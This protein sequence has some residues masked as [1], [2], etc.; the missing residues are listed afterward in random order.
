MP[1]NVVSE[2]SVALPGLLGGQPL[3]LQQ[4][5]RPLVVQP[6]VQRR[7]F[8]ID[9]GWI[10]AFDRGGER[11]GRQSPPSSKTPQLNTAP[12]AESVEGYGTR[13][14]LVVEDQ[15][16]CGEHEV[17]DQ[18]NEGDAVVRITLVRLRISWPPRR[19]RRRAGRG[20]S[21]ATVL[22]VL[23][24]PRRRGLGSSPACRRCRPCKEWRVD[25]LCKRRDP[26]RGSAR[27]RQDCV[28]SMNGA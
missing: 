20:S 3:D 12:A 4:E 19:A 7:H 15:N 18:T 27:H 2:G 10:D 16:A 23:G 25:L 21:W 22:S 13:V 9:E 28:E 14:A 5:R 6:A 8:C 26:E 24:D 11:H 17:T 1:C